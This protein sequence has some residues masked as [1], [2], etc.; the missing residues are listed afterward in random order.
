MSETRSRPEIYKQT[1]EFIQNIK[2][3]KVNKTYKR[4]KINFNMLIS[5]SIQKKQLAKTYA[6]LM[7]GIMATGNKFV[8]AQKVRMEKLMKD[9]LSDKKISELSK[10]INIISSFKIKEDINDEL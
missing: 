7:K 1:E 2:C 5:T 8:T 9:K 6:V 4:K 10:K 3:E